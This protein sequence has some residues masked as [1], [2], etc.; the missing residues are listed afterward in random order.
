ML[1][2]LVTLL[3][4]AITMV[5]VLAVSICISP[6]IVLEDVVDAIFGGKSESSSASA[7]RGGG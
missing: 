2:A 6:L 1:L 3:M 4:L 5:V 7:A